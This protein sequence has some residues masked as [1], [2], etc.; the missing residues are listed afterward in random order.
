MVAAKNILETQVG[1]PAGTQGEK[2]LAV[3]G[4]PGQHTAVSSMNGVT[5]EADPRDE[6]L[7]T[8][9]S[10]D[11]ALYNCVFNADR[12]AGLARVLA[13]MHL[14]H[15]VSDLQSVTAGAAEIP[16]YVFE[17]NSW[18]MTAAA[19]VASGQKHLTMPG[20][21]L[22]WNISW[23]EQERSSAMDEALKSFFADQAAL[24]R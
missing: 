9:D 14:A 21:Y 12:V 11:G 6:A 18:S 17:Y 1:S 24:S 4:K 22:L 10:P 13:L 15:H 3:F 16:L 8:K 23:A 5:N 19:A 2:D 7:G 20:G